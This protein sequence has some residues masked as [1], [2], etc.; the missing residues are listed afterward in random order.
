[1]ALLTNSWKSYSDKLNRQPL[2]KSNIFSRTKSEEGLLLIQ[3]VEVA[4]Q[5]FDFSC[6]SKK[7]CTQNESVIKNDIDCLLNPQKLTI[8]NCIFLRLTFS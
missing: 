7:N 4:S 2:E 5:M 3:G 8:F 6:Y 1:M